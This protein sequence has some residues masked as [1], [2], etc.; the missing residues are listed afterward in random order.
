MYDG[1]NNLMFSI[2]NDGAEIYYT[3]FWETFL[4]K[5]GLIYLSINAGAMRLLVP[6]AQED[7]LTDIGGVEYFIATYGKMEGLDGR[8]HDAV[9]LLFEDNSDT[10]YVLH[11]GMNQ[12]DRSPGNADYGRID[13]P[14]TLWTKGPNKA[15]SFF[16]RLRR[17]DRLPFMKPW[18]SK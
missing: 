9:E 15:G 2:V 10:P 5:E 4:A 16:R 12:T 18:R 3:T 6:E 13:V 1:P 17:N 11:L 14:I 7:I 8:L